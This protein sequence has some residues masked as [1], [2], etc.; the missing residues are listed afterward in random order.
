MWVDGGINWG[1]V[2][3]GV[4]ETLFGLAEGLG[5]MSAIIA[6]IPEPATKALSVVAG[7][8]AVVD[9]L[10]RGVNGLETIVNAFKN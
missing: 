3:T 6:P 8:G 2:L 1:G 4:C 5:G 7:A 9:G 10:N